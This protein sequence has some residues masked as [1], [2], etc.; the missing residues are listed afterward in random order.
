MGEARHHYVGPAPSAQ[1]CDLTY[2]PT[3]TCACACH[4]FSF[5]DW[6]SL[7]HSPSNSASLF[8]GDLALEDQAAFA[9]VSFLSILHL[10]ASQ[11][12]AKTIV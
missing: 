1:L 7:P 6:F 12:H 11:K 3:Q 5:L 10:I 4:N 2:Y 9:S 8:R